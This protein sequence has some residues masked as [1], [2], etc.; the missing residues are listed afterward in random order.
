MGEEES[1]RGEAGE[2]PRMEA[3]VGEGGGCRKKGA[4]GIL[5]DG[6][7]CLPVECGC[8]CEVDAAQVLE[9]L[10]QRDERGFGGC[11]CRSMRLFRDT[12][13]KSGTRPGSLVVLVTLA[14]EESGAFADLEL[15][16]VGRDFRG[17]VDDGDQPLGAGG[18]ERGRAVDG[19]GL[20][21]D[22]GEEVEPTCR[23]PGLA[24]A[25][26]APEARDVVEELVDDVINELL[27]EVGDKHDGG[28]RRGR[29]S[30]PHSGKPWAIISMRRKIT[31]SIRA[32]RSV[33]VMQCGE[34]RALVF[35]FGQTLYQW[36]NARKATTAAIRPFR[37]IG[38]VLVR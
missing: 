26:A 5:K 25:R 16:D 1:E 30:N 36:R 7:E 6:W 38:V 22:F 3:E 19:G 9:A 17:G 31:L 24:D 28:G 33:R 2:A 13:G 32:R 10:E 37:A 18:R 15:A 35:P 14:R 8:G 20:E 27:R 4:K 21:A 23:Q 11:P 34:F 29:T 12:V